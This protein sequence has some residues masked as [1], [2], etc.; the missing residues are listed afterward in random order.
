MALVLLSGKTVLAQC[1]NTTISGYDS[2]GPQL[3]TAN[4]LLVTGI[5]KSEC[6]SVE[7][8]PDGGSCSGWKLH[9]KAMDPNFSNGGNTIPVGYISLRYNGTG[10]STLPLSTSGGILIQNGA[11]L[12]GYY[13]VQK[14][15]FIVAPGNHLLVPNGTYSTP[16]MF[17][18]LDN[19]DNVMSSFTMSVDFQVQYWGPNLSDYCA[20]ISLSGYGGYG[21]TFSTYAQ[22]M[23][24]ATVT[25]AVTLRYSL[26]NNSTNCPGWKLTVKA[27]SPY[28][29]NGSNDVSI[30][31]AS[32]Q[33]NRTEGSGPS[34]SAIGVTTG[35]IPLSTSESV[36]IAHSNARLQAPPKGTIFTQKYD[37][38]LQVGAS[39]NLPTAGAYTVD[40]IFS[41]YDENNQ[42]ISA[43]TISDVGFQNQYN[44]NSNISLELQNGGNSANFDFSTITSRT[45]GIS[46]VKN[47][48]LKVTSHKDYQIFAQTLS[49]DLVASAS[50][51]TLPVSV[52]HLA[53]SLSSPI[54]GV[55]CYTIQLS[56]NNTQA[57]ITNTN[58][59]YPN[60]TVVYNLN[61][62]INGNDPDILY[63]PGGNY[64][65]TLV[66]V[67]Q[68]L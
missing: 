59:T 38:V 45:S 51:L 10:G 35:L 4:Q 58:P 60:Q 31:N 64:S 50:S 37:L 41:I 14:L 27:T 16:L 8:H 43:Y 67:A 29:S 6:V 52:I 1:A 49:D 3:T 61:Y 18:F 40:L 48:A 39:L 33:F 26:V 12:S 30:N 42:L 9:V 46:L 7:Y 2:G 19:N 54:S 20:D 53:A 55:S 11:T 5:T 57:L 56:A 62:F 66:F 23:A 47:N 25:D 44:G 24:G 63:A 22:L 36:V 34:G 21:Y 17:S 15:D 68:P 13:T 28:F 65:G 32:L